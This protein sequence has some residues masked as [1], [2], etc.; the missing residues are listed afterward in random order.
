VRRDEVKIFR[1]NSDAHIERL[2]HF[3][4]NSPPPV[5][6][7]APPLS[8]SQPKETLEYSNRQTQRRRWWR[9]VME[10]PVADV[11]GL[12]LLVLG[13]TILWVTSWDSLGFALSAFILLAGIFLPS[14]WIISWWVKR[15]MNR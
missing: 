7:E 15:R 3:P 9:T 6:K 2:Q 1:G 11:I 14:L 5:A 12:C 10:M 4:E 8:E 13:A